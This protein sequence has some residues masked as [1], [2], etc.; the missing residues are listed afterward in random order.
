MKF[1]ALRPAI[2]SKSDLVQVLYS[3]FRGVFK[4]N[5]FTE[6]LRQLLLSLVVLKV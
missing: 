2:L 3:E 1:H 5:F 4:N 6:Q